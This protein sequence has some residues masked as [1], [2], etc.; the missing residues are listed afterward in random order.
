KCDYSSRSMKNKET[1]GNDS[2]DVIPIQSGRF[3]KLKLNHDEL[4]ELWQSD[5]ISYSR[6]CQ[7]SHL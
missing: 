7:K 1:K 5:S 6:E 2:G 3:G 4:K